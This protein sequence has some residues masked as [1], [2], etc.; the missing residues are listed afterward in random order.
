MQRLLR[1]APVALLIALSFA[2]YANNYQHAYL[3]DDGYTVLSNPSIRSLANIPR[4]FVDPSTYTTLR[5]QADYRPVLQATY[6]LNYAMGGYDTTWWHFTQVLLHAL[7][8]LGV[9]ALARRI[10][11]LLRDPRPDGIAFVAA[12]LFAVHPS[13]AGV[14]NYFNARSSLLT[15]AFIVPA[16]LL[17]M[18]PVEAPDYA[19]PQWKSAA[20]FALAVFTKVEAIGV[21]GALWAFELWQRGRETPDRSLLAAARASFDARTLRRLAPMLAVSVVY[22]VIRWRVMAPFPFDETRHAADVG[23]YEY[24]LTQLTGWWYYVYR[25][26]APVRLVADYLAYPVY[27]TWMDPVVL[28]AAAS[29][30]AVGTAIVAAWRR[31]PH[32]AFIA[33]AALAL[34][35]PTS[36]IAPLAEMVNE[37]RPYLPMGILSLAIVIP[38]GQRLRAWPSGHARTALAASLVL[39]FFSLGALTYRRNAVFATQD[40]YW[41]DVLAKAPSSR[42]HLNYGLALMRENDMRGA[43]R[44]FHR[45][46]ELAPFW[47][48]THINLGVAYQHVGALDSAR[49]YFDRAVEYDKYSGVALTWRGESRLA[50]RDYRGARDDFLASLPI[51]L[52]RY[53]NVKGLAIAYAGLGDHAEFRAQ[54]QRL[55]EL[56]PVAAAADIGAIA[57]D[58]SAPAAAGIQAAL[59]ARG[60][61][62]LR[63]GEAAAAAAA[64]REVLAI[65]PTHYG[66]HYQLAVALDALREAADARALWEKVLLMAERYDDRTT[67]QTARSRLARTP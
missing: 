39:L 22:F 20:L 16:L 61:G 29:W 11:V 25:W 67:V 10:L 57:Q 31:A 33:I 30:L 60:L 62:A 41:R 64:F 49:V 23:A 7:V 47:Y 46:L 35:S 24:F 51:G 13:A 66:A 21:L 56:D 40:A 38:V 65:N 12:A 4:F 50:Q 44:E 3:L 9:F 54:T 17:Y 5:E 45:S 43:I 55:K 2:V 19:R 37:H 42:A 36:S 48:F 32:V 58:A 34:L 14:V 8:T 18:K 26:V 63:K 15:A 1:F 53:R 52:Q 28:L 59:M 27:R 6:A